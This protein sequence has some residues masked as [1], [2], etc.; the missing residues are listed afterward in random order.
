MTIQIYGNVWVEENLYQGEEIANLKN[1]KINPSYGDGWKY[2]GDEFISADEGNIL[3]V[4][5]DTEYLFAGKTALP[6][7]LDFLQNLKC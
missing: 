5:C 6:E 4:H 7:A 3:I 1:L 2:D